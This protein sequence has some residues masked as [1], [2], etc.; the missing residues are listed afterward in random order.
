MVEMAERVIAS[1]DK[2][3][4][5]EAEN[6]RLLDV[7]RTRDKH[8]AELQTQLIGPPGPFIIGE[9]VLMGER[10][11]DLEDYINEGKA[12]L[13]VEVPREELHSA[14]ALLFKRVRVI[15]EPC[16]PDVHEEKG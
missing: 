2:L 7:I 10:T 12:A 4:D 13:L 9:C 6:A 16:S 11:P 15:I 3:M 5:A 1:R 8:I 14:G